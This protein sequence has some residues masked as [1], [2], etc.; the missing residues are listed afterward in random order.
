M[1]HETEEQAW[2]HPDNLLYLCFKRNCSTNDHVLSRFRFPSGIHI[3]ANHPSLDSFLR[4]P[5]FSTNPLSKC[6]ILKGTIGGF[7]VSVVPE[8]H[9]AV[10][11]AGKT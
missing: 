2:E 5:A 3:Q 8:D 9:L 1:G 7:Q 4:V 6:Q 10:N 11:C